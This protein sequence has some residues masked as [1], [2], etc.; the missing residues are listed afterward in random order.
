MKKIAKATHP[1]PNWLGYI[2]WQ[3]LHA[4]E[5]ITCCDC[6]LAHQFEFRN[7]KGKLEWRAKRHKQATKLGREK[8]KIII[9]K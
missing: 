7:G 6:G 1:K 2:K 9:V 5:I 3:K 4:V 8:Y